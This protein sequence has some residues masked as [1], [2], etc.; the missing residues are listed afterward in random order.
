VGCNCSEQINRR[1][2]A[3]LWK[4]HLS[5]GRGLWRR[6]QISKRSLHSNHR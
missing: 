2:T 1:G 6:H 5:R 4:N 3:E